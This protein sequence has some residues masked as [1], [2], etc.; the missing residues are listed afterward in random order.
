MSKYKK[1]IERE[2]EKKRNRALKLAK[3]YN[4][5]KAENILLDCLKYYKENHKAR[6][7]L[8]VLKALSNGFYF[9]ADFKKCLFYTEELVKLVEKYET[10]GNYI[11]CLTNLGNILKLTGDFNRSKQVFK[12]AY[13]LSVENGTE[14]YKA[15]NLLNL[16][17]SNIIE[18]NYEIAIKYLEKGEKI[19]IRIGEEKTLGKIY[20]NYAKLYS[21]LNDMK[22]FERYLNK[23]EEIFIKIK[24]D[25]DLAELFNDVGAFFANMGDIDT[26]IDVLN[27]MLEICEENNLKSSMT[28]ALMNLGSLMS[29]KGDYV[30]GKK[31]L[32]RALKLSKDIGHEFII[33]P[34]YLYLGRNYFLSANFA[35]AEKYLELAKK[36]ATEIDYI[37]LI[38]NVEL[39]F[40]E[41][42]RIQEMYEK[43]YRHLNQALLHYHSIF[44]RLSSVELRET[45]KKVY[46]SL[47]KIL[48]EINELIESKKYEPMLLDIEQNIKI[49]TYACIKS[50]KLDENYPVEITSK[51]I[52]RLRRSAEK[53]E[54]VK[55]PTLE[56]DARE[57]YRKQF[58]YEIPTQQIN[59][60][61]EEQDSEILYNEDCLRDKNSKTIEIDVLGKKKDRDR[62]TYIIGECKHR[63][64]PLSL[65]KIKCFLI[66][67]A[68]VA[69]QKI[70][71][72]RE[73]NLS[74]PNFHLVIIS[75]GGFP[76][77]FNFNEMIDN[78]W[79]GIPKSRI[80]EKDLIE[81]D[82]FI[83]LLKEYKIP[84]EFYKK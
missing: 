5:D 75:L 37:G 64:K 19:C 71:S 22:N 45:Y 39:A 10:P 18:G 25:K 23:A 66:K 56:K 2:Y 57:L 50:K 8:E 24:A 20:Q 46:E 6:E 69:K 70:R 17:D 38:I 72:N 80:K 47:P 36:F 65:K 78:Y 53:Y 63:E 83:S 62:K 79:K 77:N 7:Q 12:K 58:G 42:N 21:Y 32:L 27:K 84:Y 13:D 61:I 34:L 51:E 52:A 43:Q 3:N 73:K 11:Q 14:L 60:I 40:A 76:E 15:M 30:R 59:R 48:H 67:A 26:A 4:Y 55:G 41:F 16:A 68:I 81:R 33:G 31:L 1:K 44:E 9:S 74:E 49:S 29:Y 35:D 28:Y 82:R 54:I